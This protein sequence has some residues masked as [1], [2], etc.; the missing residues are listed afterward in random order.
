MY[1]KKNLATWA[2]YLFCMEGGLTLRSMA[3]LLGMNLSTAFSWRH[4]ILSVTKTK[5]DKILTETIEVDEFW[6]KENFKG[7][8]SINPRFRDIENRYLII[9]L[10]C[11]D[12]QGNVFFRTA[13]RKGLRKLHKNEISD[14]LSPVIRRCK[15]LVSSRNLAYAFFAKQERLRFCMPSSASYRVEGFTLEN[16]AS[17]T[18]GFLKFLKGF[19]SVA[20]KYLS[21]YVNWYRILMNE[22][23]S[24][25]AQIMDMLSFCRGRLRTNEFSKV[26]FDGSLR[27]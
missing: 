18:R 13:A 26:Q 4:K 2:S 17:Q 7:C 10:S 27:H 8:R 14:I 20:S 25:P 16:A 23:C 6:L 5:S 11:R 12:S 22:S 1:S 3:K 24:L 19:R 9:L 15:T 21:H